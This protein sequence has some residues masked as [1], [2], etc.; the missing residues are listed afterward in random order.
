[1]EEKG[2]TVADALA[3]RDGGNGGNYGGDGM[4]G[5]NG[6]WWVIILILFFAMGGRGFGNGYG[7]NGGNDWGGVNTVV[8]PASLGGFG[9]GY[10]SYSPCCT[11]ATQQSMTDAFNFNQLDN[12]QRGLERGL[13]DGFYSVNLGIT[14]L[15]TQMQQGFCAT[16]RA[17]LQGF[18]G[19]QSTLCQ[20]FSGID[21]AIA[22]TNYNLKDCCCDTRQAI[23]ENRFT[24]QT[25]FNAL[26]NQ[27]ASCCCDLGRGQENIK[28]ALAQQTCDI[29]S[30]A[31]KNTD[32]II[33]HLVQ[34]E[35]EKLRTELQSAQFQLSQN[36]Q[37]RALIKQLQPCPKPAYLTC[38][39]YT[40]YP[41]PFSGYSNGC[42]C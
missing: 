35:M 36:S 20:G 41:Q 27:L 31:D 40:T 39:P 2:L 38:S 28:Y 21:A 12:G 23:T 25:G 14:N 22:Q 7:G 32:R 26:Q 34:S 3:L 19:I 10:G 37:T 5:G 1:M 8:V 6:A 9:G 17:N 13:C 33:N 29:I 24:T 42:G 4:F 18:N 11:P 16:D 15:G 30:N